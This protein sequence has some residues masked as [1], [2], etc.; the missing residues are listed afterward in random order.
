MSV[1]IVYIEEKNKEKY[2]IFQRLAQMG[3]RTFTTIF[4][5]FTTAEAMVL[6]SM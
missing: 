1:V 3:K 4:I 2:F 6:Y 5:H